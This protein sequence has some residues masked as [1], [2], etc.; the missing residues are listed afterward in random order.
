MASNNSGCLTAFL[1]AFGLTP[2]SRKDW[3]I[4]KMED[5]VEELPYRV[6]DDFL[7]PA[8]LSFYHVL[9]SIVGDHL[10]VLTKVRMIDLF[11][12][13]RP[14]E[15]YSYRG[16][17]SQKHIDFLLC[18]PKTMQP[19]AGIELDDASHLRQDRIERDEFVDKVFEKANLP[20][21]RFP[22]QRTYHTQEISAILKQAL[23]NRNS[24]TG[25]IANEH[26]PTKDTQPDCPKCGVKMVLRKSSTGEHKKQAIRCPTAIH[27][28]P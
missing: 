23:S 4:T 28:K 16:K 1:K 22:T 14:N 5:D 26:I 15:N 12:V 19:I 21:L 3:T 11:Y 10:T 8:E 9:K 25:S 2:D 20:L 13:V 18:R 24:R 7:S 27:P 17:I 6:R